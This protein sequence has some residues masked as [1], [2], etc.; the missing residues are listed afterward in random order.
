MSGLTNFNTT[1]F[2]IS[3]LTRFPVSKKTRA[4]GSLPLKD[5][6]QGKMGESNG[7]GSLVLLGVP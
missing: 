1:A 7:L 3:V 2:L 6:V 5:R 4:Y